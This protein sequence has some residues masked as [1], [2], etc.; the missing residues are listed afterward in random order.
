MP[1]LLVGR[2]RELELKSQTTAK[3]SWRFLIFKNITNRTNL[4]IDDQHPLKTIDY[5]PCQC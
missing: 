5:F 1:R 2:T 4:Y 3:I